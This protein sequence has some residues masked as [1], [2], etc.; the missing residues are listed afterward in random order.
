MNSNKQNTTLKSNTNKSLS[1]NVKNAANNAAKM[2]EGLATKAKNGIANAATKIKNKANQISENIKEKVSNAGN[3]TNLKEPL[4][5]WSSMTEE[6]FNSNTAISKFVGFFLCLLLFVIIFQIGMSLINRFVTPSANPYII[7]GMVESNKQKIVYV[8]PAVKDSVPIYR[9]VDQPQGIEFTWN[10]W[11]VVDNDISIP[12]N[13]RIFSKSPAPSNKYN[14]S[15]MTDVNKKFI[16]ASPGLFLTKVY[17][18]YTDV[19]DREQTDIWNALTNTTTGDGSIRNK[20]TALRT[21][22]STVNAAFSPSAGW[23]TMTVEQYNGLLNKLSKNATT[24]PG[25]SNGIV[26]DI[27]DIQT[28]ITDLYGKIQSSN[29]YTAINK[30]YLELEIVKN[31]FTTHITAMKP[32]IQTKT[33][34]LTAAELTSL[35]TPISNVKATL[36]DG[37]LFG[38]AGFA[39]DYATDMAE[40]NKDSI[41][42]SSP[43]L[44]NP[45]QYNLTLVMNTFNS[46]TDRTL[47]EKIIIENVPI[48][49]W[50]CCTIRVQGIAVDIYINGMLKK[51]Q[52]LNNVPKQNYYD[53]YIGETNGFKGYVSSLKYYNYAINYNEVQSLFLAGPSLKMLAD[54]MPSNKNDYLS[55]N[56]YFK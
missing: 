50:V 54:D 12:T 41:T 53:I 51:R 25:S 18:S 37:S 14:T 45:K 43:N 10:V 2:G 16:N 48:Q 55:V 28:L 31:K 39:L 27:T 46:D 36:A 56:W 34:N 47:Y 7:N 17:D 40:K 13:A 26:E 11:F 19:Q 35:T 33:G 32:T 30:V 9:S 4:S 8:N 24:P 42:T 38:A 5:R 20:L 49:K 6:F 44:N 3:K 29:L 52:N 22:F 21:T 1:S 23:T 15:Y